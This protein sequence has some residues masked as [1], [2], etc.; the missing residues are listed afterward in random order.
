M[1]IV[2]FILAVVPLVACSTHVQQLELKRDHL[3]RVE[4]AVNAARTVSEAGELDP[5]RYDL[6]LLLNRSLFDSVMTAFDGM[7][8]TVDAGGRP[9]RFT[10]ERI[11][12]S[13]RPGSPE[14]T[15]VAQ[16]R[17]VAS[18]ATA[19]VD[20]DSRL[21]IERDTARGDSLYL[22]VVATRIVPDLRWGP[23]SLGKWRFARRLMVLEATKVTE[24]I[25]R[26]VIP[27]QADFGFGSPARSESLTLPAGEGSITGTASFP[28]SEQKGRVVVKHIAALRNGIHLFANVETTP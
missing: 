18:G 24:R 23:L 20:M 21:L 15:L 7:A 19:H 5:A 27:T 4:S 12:T 2:R 28:S 13:F 11:R 25:P 22:R 6:Y 9:V 3:L 14:V 16:A 8:M 17:D 26:V 10:L 1:H